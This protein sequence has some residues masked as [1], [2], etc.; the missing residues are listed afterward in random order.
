MT[1]PGQAVVLKVGGSS[2]VAAVGDIAAYAKRTPRLAIV[3]GGG[4]QITARMRDHG[5]E[6]RFVG[7]RRVTD[8]H[9]LYC[10][11]AAMRDVSRALCAALLAEGLRPVPLLS[12]VVEARREPELGLVGVLP[13]ADPSAI[14]AAWEQG[15]LPV[16]AP[17]GLGTG[18]DPILNVNA[19]D[20]AAALAVALGAR[21]LVFLSD[22]PGV[23]DE[24]GELIPEIHAS[25]PPAT[26]HG[27]ML[28]KLE[29]CAA[30]VRAGVADVRIG[31]DGTV[32]VA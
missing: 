18:L 10:V 6:P 32:V 2:A 30:A 22:V 13:S 16:V 11:V 31:L 29:A 24:D 8:T 19:D 1:G 25:A 20:A 3:H 12:G 27:G 7:G 17:L 15:G 23:L 5:V 28:P 21:Q 4:P 14:E 26:A 9:A